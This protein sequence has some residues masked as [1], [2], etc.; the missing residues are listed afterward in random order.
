MRRQQREAMA[1]VAVLA[2]PPCVMCMKEASKQCSGCHAFWYCGKE[3]Q[4]KHWKVHK[5]DCGRVKELQEMTPKKLLSEMEEREQEFNKATE[6]VRRHRETAQCKT[7]WVTRA[8][9]HLREDVEDARQLPGIREHLD[10]CDADPMTNQNVTLNTLFSA[11]EG[12]SRAKSKAYY[13]KIQGVK[14]QLRS[15]AEKD[16]KA[17]TQSVVKVGGQQGLLLPG[18]QPVQGLDASAAVQEPR[19]SLT[20]AALNTTSRVQEQVGFGDTDGGENISG[21]SVNQQ[22]LEG[23]RT[24]M[25]AALGNE[26]PPMGAL[27]GS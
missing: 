22:S 18:A 9:D 26:A 1:H 11:V 13:N 17:G 16:E 27:K 12:V 8:G 5:V 24:R 2:A 6:I 19:E 7:V 25:Q 14:E 10:A 23:A 15:L 20:E 21:T 4:R 3:C